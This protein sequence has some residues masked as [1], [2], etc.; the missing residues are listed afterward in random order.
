MV[1]PAL[2]TMGLHKTAIWAH[3]AGVRGRRGIRFHETVAPPACPDC[4]DPGEVG[5][6]GDLYCGRCA[7]E[8]LISVLRAEVGGGRNTVDAIDQGKGVLS[9]R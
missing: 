3:N 7:L 9:D 1:S 5:F 6:A 4:A 2:R 8:R